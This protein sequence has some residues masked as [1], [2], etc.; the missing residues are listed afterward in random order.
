MYISEKIRS[1]VNNHDSCNNEKNISGLN[2]HKN[3]DDIWPYE[4]NSSSI[5]G[6]DAT[7]RPTD[8]CQIQSTACS[9]LAKHA[10]L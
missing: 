4:N 1:A 6:T 3:R 10:A 5:L 9:L 7:G 8:Y 2:N